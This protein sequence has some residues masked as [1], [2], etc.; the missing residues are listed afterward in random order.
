MNQPNDPARPRIPRATYR[1]QFNRDFTFAQATEILEY[2]RDLGVTDVY[3]SPLFQA[4][5]DST[6]GYDICCFGKI[7]PNIGSEETF[8]RFTAQREKLGLGL[9]LD[10]VPNHM[11][12]ALSNG[13]WL[14]V[15]EHGPESRYGSFFDIDWNPDHPALKNK[16]LLP[17]LG[18]HYDKV[19]ER[20]ELKL[21]SENGKFFI[22]YFD[23]KFPVAAKTLPFSPPQNAIE[24][25]RVLAEFNGV[26]TDQ[27]QTS[28]RSNIKMSATIPG[29]SNT[30]SPPSEAGGEGR[31]E[32]A[33]SSKSPHPAPLPTL[34][35]GERELINAQGS[36][37]PSSDCLHALIQQ[38]HYRL[39]FWRVAS[40]EI[41]YRRFF[42]VTELVS[43]RMDLPDVFAASHEKIFTWL[44]SK[45]ITGLRIDHPDGLLDPKQYFE[46]LQT[47]AAEIGIRKLYVVVEKILSG[48]EP[49]PHDWPVWGTT[50]YDFLNR[51][52]G[53]FVDSANAQSFTE[54]Y[55]KF[56]GA[57]SSATQPFSELVQ[58][59]KRRILE[60]S[61][62]SE[63]DSLTHRLQN[64]AAKTSA[65][66][67]FTFNQL[68]AALKE[69]IAAF[70]VY[71]T[72]LTRESAH[73]SAQDS[74]MIRQAIDLAKTSAP[75][76]DS[77]IF[78]FIES[79]L[80]LKLILELDLE[81]AD[82]A[83]EFV[84]R[85]QQLTGPVMAKGLEDTTFYNF[86]RLISL[87]EVGGDPDR[88][89]ASVQA[90]HEA[91]LNTAKHW[92]HTLL[93][94]A[95]HDTKRGEDA[96]ARINVLSEIPEEWD[97]ALTRWRQWNAD[98]NV[99]LNGKP[100]PTA[101][102][103]YLLYQSLVG[104]LPENADDLETLAAFRQR[105]SAFLLKAVKE[106]KANTSWTEPNADYETAVQEFTERVL[107]DNSNNLFLNDLKKFVRR[108]AF[109]GRINSLA[110][111]VL[112]IA[113]PGVPD[114]YQG[115]ELWDFSFV[116]PDNRRPV[117]YNLRRRFLDE[118]KESNSAPQ[119]DASGKAKL[120][121]I[122][123]AL[124]FRS[125]F[126]ELFESGDYISL[127][128]RGERVNHVCS[129][130]RSLGGKSVIVIVPRLVCGLVRG[131]EVLPC[132]EKIWND[133]TIELP[134]SWPAAKF[135]NVLTGEELGVEK[136]D[137]VQILP[138]GEA[139]K[140]FP[141]A[142][143]SAA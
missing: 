95:T 58:Q 101:N 73:P 70:P 20:G 81:T 66:I 82:P 13:W 5:P 74:A 91:N 28:N 92:P 65:G 50:G 59:N 114:F 34:R 57:D 99:Q 45:A 87:N 90:F 33:F 115:T 133:T 64:V 88:F 89:G 112:K 103:E 35:C 23:K 31:G 129:F 30:P 121:V 110:Q 80:S 6:H 72:Y 141:V 96:R 97:R 18:D 48:D 136:R 140:T 128:V 118:I 132:G 124:E 116:D 139:L 38:Q 21:V 60:T 4:G 130:G 120:F 69:I 71:R 131:E 10:M 16:V 26:S 105:A 17:V 11:G 68:K 44:K 102:D 2:L 123:R 127:S 15:L 104:A 137:G 135:H 98:K 41:N 49:L 111:T 39:A 138:L 36:R 46:R 54:I 86:N 8:E 142:C 143:L 79:L 61:L 122:H 94:T 56:A 75:I 3:A 51:V 53:L 63:L 134:T 100:A 14:D 40:E 125:R 108:I 119:L 55:Q 76:S 25:E 62:I 7:N 43:L 52:N 85:F 109:F 117:D 22:S 83:R 42:D 27:A 107:T 84:L 37:Q 77:S 9:L 106:A 24:L 12:A 113:S 93:A 78:E 67:D 126:R 32:E 47:G 1:L 29:L 19:L